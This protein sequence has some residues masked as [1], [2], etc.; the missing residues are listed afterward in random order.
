MDGTLSQSCAA[1]NLFDRP[2]MERLGLSVPV[3]LVAKSKLLAD[4]RDMVEFIK[5]LVDSEIRHHELTELKGRGKGLAA[6]L[7]HALEGGRAVPDVTHIDLD[8]VL[9]KEAESLTAPWAATF[10]VEDGQ[11]AV[12][13]G[14]GFERGGGIRDAPP[15]L[16]SAAGAGFRQPQSVECGEEGSVCEGRDPTQRSINNE[17]R[18]RREFIGLAKWIFATFGCF[19][20]PWTR[21]HESSQLAECPF[22]GLMNLPCSRPKRELCKGLGSKDRCLHDG[23]V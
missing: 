4:L 15:C 9:G 14:T 7:D 16:E 5:K 23:R 10:D 6:D 13:D 22:D 17:T 8:A 19:V 2:R 18:E 11:V 21:S 1:G 3:L 12:H 20:A